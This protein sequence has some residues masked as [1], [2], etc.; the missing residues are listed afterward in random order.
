MSDYVPRHNRP[1]KESP[2]AVKTKRAASS[3]ADSSGQLTI[4]ALFDDDDFSAVEPEAASGGGIPVA[5]PDAASG[6]GIPEARHDA[7]IGGGGITV[8]GPDAASGGGIPEIGPDAPSVDKDALEARLSSSPGGETASEPERV[9]ASEDDGSLKAR[10]AVVSEDKPVKRKPDV[11]SVGDASLKARLA[12]VSGDED[13]LKAR[14]VAPTAICGSLESG[15]EPFQRAD[16]S[17]HVGSEEEASKDALSIDDAS[18]EDPSLEEA[19][20]EL[21]SIDDELLDAI[22]DADKEVREHPELA[23]PDLGAV[24]ADIEADDPEL[25]PTRKRRRWPVTI[26]IILT[27]IIVGGATTYFVLSSQALEREARRTEGYA[28]LDEAIALIQESDQVIISLDLAV[29]TEVTEANIAERGML[30]ERVPTALDTLDIA[31]EK[32]RAAVE[33]LTAPDDLEFAEQVIQAVT[34]RKDMLTSGEVII[35]KDIEAMESALIF[36]RAWELIINADTE[37]RA[38]TQ[39][40]LNNVFN[41]LYEAI[42]RN[43]AIINSLEHASELLTQAQEAFKEADF[44][45]ISQYVTLKK[46]S[47]QLAIEADQ[48]ILEGNFDAYSAKNIEFGLKDAAVVEA[49][50]RLPF[51][52]LTLITDAYDVATA[53]FRAQYFSARANAAEADALIREYVGVETQTEVQ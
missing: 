7:V 36:G 5:E 6:G 27:V 34:N 50:S 8:A 45:T 18:K 4:D 13:S 53:E 42:D 25:T 47:V 44:A 17:T 16:T 14:P 24:G 51:E 2:E 46:E 10:L 12:V 26:A 32:A 19:S 23:D 52:P 22:L 11:P 21:P 1:K 38:T 49:A 41:E 48:F 39:L 30:L 3:D 37:L 35:T 20:K 33:L 29:T 28:L 9:F 40:S 15:T 31:N 43:N